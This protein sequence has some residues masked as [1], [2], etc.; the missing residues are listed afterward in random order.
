MCQLGILRIEKRRVIVVAKY[1]FL[2]LLAD[3]KK[4]K[5]LTHRS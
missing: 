1:N 5:Q 4:I 2:G 3:L